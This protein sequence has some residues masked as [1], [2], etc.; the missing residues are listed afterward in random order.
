MVFPKKCLSIDIGNNQIKIADVVRKGDRVK[1]LNYDIIPTP[2]GTI[3][4]GFI[5][6]KLAIAGIIKECVKRNKFKSKE[7]IFTL[8]SSRII[9]REVDFPNISPSKLN[10]IIDINAEEYFPVN[11]IDYTLGHTIIDTVEEEGDK[12]LRVSIIAALTGLI[13]EYVEVANLAELKIMGIDYAGNSLSNYVKREKFEG[14]NI[15]LDFGYETTMVSIVKDG[16]TKFNRNL[17]Y[18]SGLLL[19]CIKK[20]FEVADDEAVRISRERPLL[21][22]DEN[23][24]PYLSNDIT[25]S[26][27]QILN[28]VSRLMDY[29]T[30]RNNDKFNK[31]YI[32]GGG[33]DICNVNDYIGKFFNVPAE[34]LDGTTGYYNGIKDFEEVKH[35]FATVIGACFSDVSLVPKSLLAQT[36]AKSN[37]RIFVLLAI[38]L[39]LTGAYFS[40]N[41]IRDVV[42]LKSEKAELE[43]NISDGQY[44]IELKAEYDASVKQNSFRNSILDVSTS[45]TQGFNNVLTVME[46]KMPTEVVYLSINNSEDGLDMKC[47][48]KDSMTVAKFIETLKDSGYREINVPSITTS[49]EGDSALVSFTISC[50]YPESGVPK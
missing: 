29:Y 7:A 42:S 6:D 1:V 43:Q 24:N 19:E 39:L 27:N 45:T 17:L 2:M 47:V 14:T 16:V 26:M 31:I 22:V 36:Q 46:E 35:Y 9:T 44:I 12:K 34:R 49:G 38:L 41:Q 48:A 13:E 33:S 21:N 10:S 30:S 40:I 4:D 8:A 23:E 5:L 15:I 37:R 20:H 3:S 32:V 11:L 28:G 18:G 25:G 50:E